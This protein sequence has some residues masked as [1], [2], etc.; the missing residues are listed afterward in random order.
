MHKYDFYSKGSQWSVYFSTPFE[1]HNTVGERKD[2]FDAFGGF[3][4][5]YAGIEGVLNEV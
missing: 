4:V 2:Y 3:Y 1:S 5:V